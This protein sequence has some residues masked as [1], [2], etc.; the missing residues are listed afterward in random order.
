[1]RRRT[2]PSPATEFLVAQD[3]VGNLEGLRR[4]PLTP[5]QHAPGEDLR[6]QGADEHAEA[7][8]RQAVRAQ[9]RRERRKQSFGGLRTIRRVH[10]PHGVRVRGVEAHARLRGDLLPIGPPGI[11]HVPLESEQASDLVRVLGRR[12]VAPDGVLEARIPGPDVPVAR[13][14]LERTVRAQ[15]ARFP[16]LDR[17]VFAGEVVRRRLPRFL[18]QTHREGLGETDADG[19]HGDARRRAFDHDAVAATFHV[20]SPVRKTHGS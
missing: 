9:V 19:I 16:V 18:Q 20:R 7:Q 13:I 10:E 5:I 4:V 15:G 3:V 2:P 17:D 11:H 6:V 8:Q 12:L 1:M 14:A